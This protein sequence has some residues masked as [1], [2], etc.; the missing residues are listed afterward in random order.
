[1]PK[2]KNA[3]YFIL[4][5]L[6]CLLIG[7]RLASAQAPT[8]KKCDHDSTRMSRFV[9]DGQPVSGF[10]PIVAISFNGTELGWT[11]KDDQGVYAGILNVDKDTKLPPDFSSRFKGQFFWAIYSACDKYAYAIY[12]PTPEQVKAFK[13]NPK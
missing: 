12:G 2:F 11:F 9:S 5:L 1:M 3:A 8:L 4:A 13:K 6:V 7:F 10:F